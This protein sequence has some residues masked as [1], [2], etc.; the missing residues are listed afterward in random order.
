M[1]AG[2]TGDKVSMHWSEGW[3]RLVLGDDKNILCDYCQAQLA[4]IVI[5]VI[6]VFACLD[7]VYETQPA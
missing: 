6:C 4:I 7:N 1:P 5:I 2:T 3:C